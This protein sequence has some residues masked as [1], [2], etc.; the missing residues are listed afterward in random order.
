MNIVYFHHKMFFFEQSLLF[1][2]DWRKQGCAHEEL[3]LE[4]HL[5]ELS[6]RS[7]HFGE[8]ATQEKNSEKE[9][10]HATDGFNLKGKFF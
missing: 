1:V 4:E 9:L 10:P 2:T 7:A 3:L 5:Q 8:A 6:G